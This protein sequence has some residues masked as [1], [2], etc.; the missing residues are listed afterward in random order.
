MPVAAGA[1][2]VAK[3]GGFEWTARQR[4]FNSAAIAPAIIA[5]GAAL[6]GILILTKGGAQNY[7]GADVF[8]L[9][10]ITTVLAAFVAGMLAAYLV[11]RLVRR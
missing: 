8:L 3:K 1:A 7:G 9:Q 5:V 6:F 10:A 4:V 2:W 11:E